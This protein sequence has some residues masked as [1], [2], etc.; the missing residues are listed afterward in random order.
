M[1][2][3]TSITSISSLTSTTYNYNNTITTYSTSTIKP[4]ATL[5]ITSSTPFETTNIDQNETSASIAMMYDMDETVGIVMDIIA[6]ADYKT[7]HIVI[8]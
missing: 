7:I 2:S 1:I 8:L 4:F 5:T 3:T 6:V